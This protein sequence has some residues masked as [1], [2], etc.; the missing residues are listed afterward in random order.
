M[1]NTGVP[2]LAVHDLLTQIHR[3]VGKDLLEFLRSH[4][5][6]GDMRYVRIVPIVGQ[7]VRHPRVQT[8][9]LQSV[10]RLVGFT[11]TLVGDEV[12]RLRHGE[13]TPRPDAL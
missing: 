4:V 2:F 8:E 10:P 11:L 12:R 13:T 3:I 6:A 5:V 1:V 7:L 9:A